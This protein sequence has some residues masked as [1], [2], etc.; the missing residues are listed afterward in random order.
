[1]TFGGDKFFSEKL[2]FFEPTYTHHYDQSFGSINTELD[3]WD[4]LVDGPTPQQDDSDYEPYN[5]YT[6]EYWENALPH[7]VV[8][9]DGYTF[10]D[11]CYY[12]DSDNFS[13]HTLDPFDLY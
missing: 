8:D 9:W 2:D 10:R 6:I 12:D 13:I 5:W 3:N 7:Q 11:L 4:P 1:M